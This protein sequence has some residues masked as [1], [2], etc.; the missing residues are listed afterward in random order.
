MAE[1]SSV[2]QHILKILGYLKKLKKLIAPMHADSAEDIIL[3]SLP[4]YYRDVVMHLHLRE[5]VMTLN[6][7]HQTLKQAEANMNRH[8]EEKN[9]L[10]VSQNSKKVQKRKD[11]KKIPK[12]NKRNGGAQA[13][14]SKDKKKNSSTSQ[15]E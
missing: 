11:T 1:G 4:P 10:A 3:G 15:I 13:S 5:K 6:E 2:N 14:T 7:I 9:I 8:K 12:K